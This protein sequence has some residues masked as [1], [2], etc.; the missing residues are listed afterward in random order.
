MTTPDPNITLTRPSTEATSVSTGG[1]EETLPPPDASSIHAKTKNHNIRV[2]SV[3]L[4]AAGKGGDAVLQSLHT[5]PAGLTQA[6]AEARART[7]SPNEVSVNLCLASASS[8]YCGGAV[9]V[10]VVC[11]PGGCTVSDWVESAPSR[12]AVIT[13]VP[14]AESCV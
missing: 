10:V 11:A 9:V 6:E 1:A 3:V 4:D 8:S 13:G 5:T 7:A 14:G 2:S 12:F